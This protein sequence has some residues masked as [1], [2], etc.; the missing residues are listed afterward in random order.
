MIKGLTLSV[1]L[2][3]SATFTSCTNLIIRMTGNKPSEI[4]AGCETL[5]SG[6]MLHPLSN[7]LLVMGERI[8]ENPDSLFDSKKRLVE[9]I[10]PKIRFQRAT[11]ITSFDGYQVPV[12]IYNNARK[13]RRGDQEVIVFYHGGGFVWGDIEVYDNLCSRIAQ[14]TG[15][16]LVSVGYRLAPDYTYP[17]AL[18]DSEWV[19]RWAHKNI[20]SYGGAPSK[21]TVMGDSA[22]GNLAA[23]LSLLSGSGEND[24]P[25]IK[26][27]VL[28]YPVTI[29]TDSITPSRYYF[30]LGVDRSMIPGENFFE[31][32]LD[33]Y[34]GDVV[35]AE[36]PLISPHFAEFH[37]GMPDALIITAAC[38][39]LR[40]EG[41]AY[42]GFLENSGNRV[43]Y[44]EYDGMIHGFVSIYHIFKKG[45][46]ALNVIEEFINDSK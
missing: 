34:L 37:A 36:D 15:A 33:A 14:K 10:T 2:A 1:L 16:V 44:K 30:L 43:V 21:I 28:I 46:D 41:R 26:S 4:R 27:Q 42:A 38:D 40:D 7:L 5:E 18:K 19:L 45:R 6:T 29:M 11:L 12:R 39:P 23:V 9:V 35:D 20:G 8:S 32:A 22:G 25:P 24:F 3:V 13:G 31:Y 17:Y